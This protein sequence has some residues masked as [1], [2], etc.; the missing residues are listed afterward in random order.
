MV[1]HAEWF[2]LREFIRC[3]MQNGPFCEN[4]YGAARRMVRFARI[5]MVLHAERFVLREFIRCCMQKG[6]FCENLDGA[7]CR[8]YPITIVRS[9]ALCV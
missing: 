3:C 8:R 9:C 6:P 5:R 4:S 7:A 1:L 2:V